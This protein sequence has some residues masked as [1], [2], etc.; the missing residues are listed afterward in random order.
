MAETPTTSLLKYQQFQNGMEISVQESTKN[1]ITFEVG[2]EG[3]SFCNL[4]KTEAWND[5]EITVA[6]YTISHPLI[7]KPRFI[8]EAKSDPKK[9]IKGAAGRVSKFF[10]KLEKEL[11][12]L[13]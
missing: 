12:K 7:A 3:H 9:A 2:G 11:S 8:V 5:K 4:L 13:K 10:G 1:R 6:T